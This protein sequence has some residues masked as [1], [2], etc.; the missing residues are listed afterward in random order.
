MRLFVVSLSRGRSPAPKK[1]RLFYKVTATGLVGFPLRSQARSAAR[2]PRGQCPSAR[3]YES[4]DAVK[5][6]GCLRI[7]CNGCLALNGSRTMF[8]NIESK[9]LWTTA[10]TCHGQKTVLL[11]IC[12]ARMSSK[13]RHNDH[14]LLDHIRSSIDQVNQLGRADVHGSFAY[15]CLLCR[16]VVLRLSAYSQ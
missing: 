6:L 15:F 9:D 16:V 13:R 8:A 7:P 11:G 12:R 10:H 14:G 4:A 3:E 5:T 2:R 1:G